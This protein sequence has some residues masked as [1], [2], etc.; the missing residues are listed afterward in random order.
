VWTVTH[1]HSSIPPH[2]DSLPNPL[3]HHYTLCVCAYVCVQY[4]AFDLWHCAFDLSK[5]P[6]RRLWGKG[7]FVTSTLRVCYMFSLSLYVCVS[8]SVC[9]V[10]L[11][12]PHTYSHSHY[13]HHA[14]GMSLPATPL[15]TQ[16]T[17]LVH[18]SVRSASAPSATAGGG[19]S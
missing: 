1:P 7:T 12:S 16:H 11:L 15:T 17:P 10:C 8:L 18:V 4:S 3:P 19:S 2:S 5:A 13:H 6:Q 14:T 9:S